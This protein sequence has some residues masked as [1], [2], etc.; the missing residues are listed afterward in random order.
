MS[1]KPT[2]ELTP[3]DEDVSRQHD[4][5]DGIVYAGKL[6]LK[7]RKPR[8]VAQLRLVSVVGAEDAKNQVYMSLVSPLLWIESIDDEPV[9]MV[10]SKRELEALFE[11]VGD[12]GL[13]AI[14]E[15]ISEQF[16]PDSKAL[17]SEAK[18]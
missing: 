13:T 8:A 15:H 2:L 1:K 17:E 4:A 5:Q 16:Q 12:D 9:G 6:K 10:V 14:I 3:V 18:N 7:I 11:R